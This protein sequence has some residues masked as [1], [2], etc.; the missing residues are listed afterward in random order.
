[1]HD[2]PRGEQGRSASKGRAGVRATPRERIDERLQE[3]SMVA[4]YWLFFM[5]LLVLTVAASLL[6]MNF[7]FG[8]RI[9][10]V[11][12]PVL[13]LGAFTV[14]AVIVGALFAQVVVRS[15][16]RPIREMSAAASAMAHGDFDIELHE[17]T[18]AVEVS[19][20]AESFTAMARELSATE[21]LRNDFVS[22][23]S[24][25]MKTPVATIKGYAALLQA[26]GLSDADR[27]AYAQKVQQAAERLG[28]ITD[29]TLLLSHLEQEDM[30]VESAPFSLDEQIREVLLMFEPRWDEGARDLEVDLDD[31][32]YDGSETLLAHV[33]QN[34]I[35]NALKFTAQGDAIRVTL[36]REPLGAGAAQVVVRVADTGCGMDAETCRRAFEKFYQADRSHATEGSGLGLALAKRIVDLHGGTIEVESA[37]GAGAIFTVRLPDAH[38]A[39]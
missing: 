1:M 34:L 5:G 6:V 27:C 2:T 3:L 24:H 37:P 35:G 14:V 31:V 18:L 25:E 10:E 23:V 33:W 26:P 8:L 22:N 4:L 29:N 38:Q 20:M 19:Q 16:T 28:A 39:G 36:A 7:L 11:P 32:V 9:L 12:G 15:I 21:M 30:E 13:L 17:K